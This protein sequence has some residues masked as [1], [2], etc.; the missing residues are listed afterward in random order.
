MK[1][2]ANIIELDISSPDTRLIFAPCGGVWVASINE[3]YSLYRDSYFN[4]LFNIEENELYNL[5][6]I[7]SISVDNDRGYIE[8]FSLEALYKQN[9]SYYQYKKDNIN[10]IAVHFNNFETPYSKNNIIIN[11]KRLFSTREWLDSNNNLITE[12]NNMYIESRVE[13]IDTADIE[14]DFL[15]LTVQYIEK[16]YAN[17]KFPGGY[18]KREGKPNEFEILTSRLIDRSLRPLFPKSYRYPI[19]ITIIVLSIDRELDLQTLSLNAASIALLISDLPIDRA[20]NAIR[21]GRI[22]DEFII[23]PTLEQM[24]Q[25]SIDLFISGENEN[26]FNRIQNTVRSVIIVFVMLSIVIASAKFLITNFVPLP[27]LKTVVS[28]EL[29][30]RTFI[31]SSVS[32]SLCSN[33]VQSTNNV[34]ILLSLFVFVYISNTLPSLSQEKRPIPFAPAVCGLILSLYDSFLFS[35]FFSEYATN[36]HLLIMSSLVIPLPLSSISIVSFKKLIFTWVAPAS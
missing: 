36:N 8:V 2:F 7:G 13:E 27:F 33:L 3:I 1:S 4:E 9:K 15:P 22:N 11:I 6:N 30:Y 23:N 19:Q 18:I 12:L 34:L 35:S 25:S 31:D 28:V 14:G 16:S 29:V 26:I 17:G 21:I 5:F 10:Y 24:K 32:K 20:I